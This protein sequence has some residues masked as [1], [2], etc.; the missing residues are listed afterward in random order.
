LTNLSTTVS[1]PQSFKMVKPKNSV[2]V[3]TQAHRTWSRGQLGFTQRAAADESWCALLS[4][5]DIVI[6]SRNAL[7]WVFAIRRAYRRLGLQP[8]YFIDER[9]SRLYRKLAGWL[10][11]ETSTLRGTAA[12]L[13]PMLP[14]IV[15]ACASE[16]ILRVDDDEIPSAALVHWLKQSLRVIDRRVV[17]IPRRALM[18][19]GE[20][21]FFTDKIPN[22]GRQDYQFRLFRREGI[23]FTSQIH[24]AGIEFAEGD[25]AYAPDECCLYHFDWIVR[26]HRERASKLKTYESIRAGTEDFFRPQYL[27]EELDLISYSFEPVVDPEVITLAKHLRSSK[28]LYG[29]LK[30][31]Q[32]RMFAVG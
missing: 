2:S 8:R 3:S 10:L 12:H 5:I 18:F 19:H 7:P 17:A 15:E 31:I 11:S 13:E 25:I 29:K 24:T 22:L 6:P 30:T 21:L 4:T 16:W 1:L 27:P 14:E 26:D 20:D 23:K 9:S 32:R 28:R